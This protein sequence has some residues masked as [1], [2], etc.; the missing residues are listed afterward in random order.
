MR[1]K[2]LIHQRAE[3]LLDQIK[4]GQYVLWNEASARMLNGVV[5]DVS[6]NGSTTGV[7][8]DLKYGAVPT[9]DWD[10]V[11]VVITAGGTFSAKSS[12]TSIKYKVLTK[13]D[14]G[15]AT[16][17]SNAELIDGGY[18]SMAYGISIRFSERC[19][20]YK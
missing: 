10:D 6:V 11:R 12:N 8:E 17:E 5:T 9:I 15:I 3:G 4:R 16:R 20:Y 7:I 19:L 18:Q 13:N 1:T 14:D 2:Y